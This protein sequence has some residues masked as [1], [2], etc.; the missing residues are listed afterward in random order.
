M[1]PLRPLRPTKMQLIVFSEYFSLSFGRKRGRK[2][3][4]DA[5]CGRKLLPWTQTPLF[6][7]RVFPASFLAF[8]RKGRNGRKKAALFFFRRIFCDDSRAFGATSTQ[9]D[10]NSRRA[11]PARRGRAERRID[12]AAPPGDPCAEGGAPDGAGADSA[13]PRC[14]YHRPAWHCPG[15]ATRAA[16]PVSSGDAV[17]ALALSML[18]RHAA[19]AVHLRR[20]DLWKVSPAGVDGIGGNMV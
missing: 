20:G 15:T 12:R 19:L 13:C 6:A 14:R 11:R 4:S 18:S 7:S 17:S 9:R 8:G 3:I 5:N 2:L 16:R 1:R 10:S